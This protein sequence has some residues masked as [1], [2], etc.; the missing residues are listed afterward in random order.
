M[1]NRKRFAINTFAQIFT[2]IVSLGITFFLTPYI[3]NRLGAA[4]YG[5][6]G[7]ANNFVSYVQLLTI[8]LNSM[9][10]RFIA[11]HVHKNQMDDARKYFSSVF[12][13]NLFLVSIISV[14]SIVV[15]YQLEYIIKIP[16]N[17]LNDVKLLF[18]CTFVNF[19]ISLVFN[20]FNTS[21]FIKNRLDLSS[22]RT[23]ISNIIRAILLIL[24]FYLFA[25]AVWFIGLVSII[26]TIYIVITNIHFRNKLVPE[27]KVSIKYFDFAKIKELISSGVWSVVSKVNGIMGHG[28]ELLIAN[29][30][31]GAG[32]MG[33][34]A[35][36]RRIPSL[37]LGLYEKINAVFAPP[38][39]KLYAEGKQKE[40]EKELSKA[41]R[42]FGFISFIPTAILFVFCDWSYELWLP[43]QNARQLYLV[44]LVAC[45]DLPFSMPL[46]PIY[47]IYVITNRIRANSLF[48][49]GLYA[50][51]LICV[52][53]GVHLTDNILYLLIILGGTSSVFKL[54][55][56]LTFLPIYGAYCA[57]MKVGLLYKNTFKSV[58]AL[59]VL[60]PI[61]FMIRNI[62]DSPSWVNLFLCVG[63][64]FVLGS[65]LGCLFILNARDR[66]VLLEIIQKVK[67]KIY[68]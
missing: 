33:I 55:K 29:L 49:L 51:V 4:A 46:Q 40:L 18:L 52:L 53:V 39:I 15:I 41:I 11:L 9:A 16:E 21:T 60:L 31:V 10:S 20:V 45:V 59:F 61:L 37:M 64:S 6:V 24:L 7:L 23:I 43:S 48:G 25:P 2:F 42:F 56:S 67:S 58:F 32:P 19:F 62:F 1:G 14:I 26:C 34:L 12:F 63:I 36:S 35:I 30:F 3:V 28:L 47:N 44:T 17:L 27:L 65:V 54:L 13:S 57:K 5:F 22:T 38:W 68:R 50:G 8:A 66:L